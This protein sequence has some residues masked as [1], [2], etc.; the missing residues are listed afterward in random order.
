[1][2]L[3][4]VSGIK[5]TFA[6]RLSSNGQWTEDEMKLSIDKVRNKGVS[7]RKAADTFSGPKSS[8][9]DGLRT[10]HEGGMVKTTFDIG[11]FRRTYADEMEEQLVR[12]VKY[13]QQ[14][15]LGA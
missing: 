9:L 10:L 11:W 13:L 14:R 1:M 5:I 4:F 8:L 15:W 6:I 7:V 3:Y 12:H 2:F